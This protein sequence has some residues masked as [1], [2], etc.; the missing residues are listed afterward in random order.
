MASVASEARRPIT[1]LEQISAHLQHLLVQFKPS[2]LVLKVGCAA[3]G[4]IVCQVEDKQLPHLIHGV[5]VERT[6]DFK[7]WEV[8]A[9][10]REVE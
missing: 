6:S 3:E 2:E 9:N 8:F 10:G 7:G 4:S 5:R 1:A